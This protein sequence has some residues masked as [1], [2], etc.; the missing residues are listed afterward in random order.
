MWASEIDAFT[1]TLFS[2]GKHLSHSPLTGSNGRTGLGLLARAFKAVIIPHLRPVH[3]E[4]R[5]VRSRQS[6][7]YTRRDRDW[8]PPQS[9]R[10]Y[11]PYKR[12]SYSTY[13][14]PPPPP[15]RMR[16]IDQ[17]T[18]DTPSSFPP[19]QHRSNFSTHSNSQ[20][21]P[22]HQSSHYTQDY[23]RGYPQ[24]SPVWWRSKS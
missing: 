4:E 10:D 11:V 13:S 1:K 14:P 7:Q 16:Y 8:Q 9:D 6:R 17:D 2:D 3:H 22:L 21:L 12:S 24:R 20:P 19:L 18:R 15:P 5:F 23:E